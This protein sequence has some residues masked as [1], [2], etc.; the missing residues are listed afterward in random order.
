MAHSAVEGDLSH[1]SHIAWQSPPF[2]GRFCDGTTV[3]P[4]MSHNLGADL[5]QLLPECRQ[6]PLSYGL[7]QSQDAHEVGQIV[8]QG[9]KLEPDGVV[10]FA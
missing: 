9:V 10:A 3:A 6:R 1:G 7:E 4:A 2:V 5:D 8:G